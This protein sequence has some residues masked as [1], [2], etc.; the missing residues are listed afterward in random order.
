MLTDILPKLKNSRFYARNRSKFYLVSLR[1]IYIA[2]NDAG[3]VDFGPEAEMPP[4]LR[5]R[6]E[7]MIKM[8]KCIWSTN[9]CPYTVN[10]TLLEKLLNRPQLLINFREI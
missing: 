2:I 7:K 3:F 6:S 9:I 8:Q 1:E 5:I 4:F 10:K